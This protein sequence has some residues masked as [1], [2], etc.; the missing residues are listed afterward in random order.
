MINRTMTL[1]VAVVGLAFCAPRAC[2]QPANDLCANAIAIAN[3]LTSGNN[4][5][6][7]AS[8]PVE[9]CGG[10]VSNDVWYVYTAPCTGLA[11]VGTCAPGS[12]TFDT[13]L[14]VWNGNGGC[15]A[16]NVVN[17]SDDFPGCGLASKVEFFVQAG[18]AYYISIGGYG[19]ASGTFT[20][21]LTCIYWGVVLVG[22]N[23]CA[24]A[25]PIVE[26]VSI[27]DCNIGAS[28][29][30]GEPL[31]PCAPNDADVWYVFTA[32]TTG[33][34]T[35]TT[36]H[37]STTFDTVLAAWAGTC[38]API[39]LACNDDSCGPPSGSTRSTLSF[40]TLAGTTVR[41]SVGG[42]NGATGDF[43]LTVTPNSEQLGLSYF[44]VGPGTLGFHLFGGPPGGGYFVPTTVNAGAYPFGWCLGIDITLAELAA[45]VNT[46]PFVGTLGPCGHLRVGPFTGLPGGLSVYGVAVANPPGSPTVFEISKPDTFTVP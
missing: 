46:P 2:A 13:V 19:G 37:L 4:I 34:Y 14:T 45:E 25:A 27:A 12:A 17:C 3:G 6:A 5:G 41:I 22:N 28:A 40:S 10:V 30:F 1:S 11:S 43:V 8:H 15:C 44:H 36:C 38:A 31:A 24:N 18:K 32:S 26:H 23:N 29:G 39:L 35:V 9:P 7:T 42:F 33:S 20:L 16:L 21:N